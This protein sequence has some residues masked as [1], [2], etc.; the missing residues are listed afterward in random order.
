M[1]Y[2]VHP[3]INNGIFVPCL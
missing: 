1:T 3:L 2:S